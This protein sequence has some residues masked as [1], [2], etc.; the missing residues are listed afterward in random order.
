MSQTNYQPIL[1]MQFQPEF[2]S[3]N[4]VLELNSCA[5]DTDYPVD[6]TNSRNPS[7]LVADTLEAAV[8]EAGFV[9]HDIDFHECD[10]CGTLNFVLTVRPDRC[11][12]EGCDCGSPRGE[13]YISASDVVRITHLIGEVDGV[14]SFEVSATSKLLEADRE[15]NSVK[16]DERWWNEFKNCDIRKEGEAGNDKKKLLLN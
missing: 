7:S 1:I 14:T 12:V 11:D 6:E 13:R 8:N 16:V 2:L 9:M 10:D 4:I 5:I 15:R 3:I